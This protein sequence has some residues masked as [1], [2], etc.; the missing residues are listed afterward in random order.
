M[1]TTKKVRAIGALF[2]CLGAFS[3]G[4]AEA[5]AEAVGGGSRYIIYFLSV[6]TLKNQ[7]KKESRA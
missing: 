1:N 2:F 3:V 4:R 7:K 5:V 6:I